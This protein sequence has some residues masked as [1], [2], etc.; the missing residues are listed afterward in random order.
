MCKLYTG[1]LRAYIS[2]VAGGLGQGGSQ[3]DGE[4]AGNGAKS[5]DD[6]PH[7]VQVVDVCKGACHVSTRCLHVQVRCWMRDPTYFLPQVR[8]L[9]RKDGTLPLSVE[10][11]TVSIHIEQCSILQLQHK[12]W[13]KSARTLTIVDNGVVEA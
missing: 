11:L 10:Q 8:K 6:T 4:D 1:A 2:G 3:V 5:D 12:D 9:M 13:K 7:I